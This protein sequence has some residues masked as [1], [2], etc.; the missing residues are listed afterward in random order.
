[1]KGGRKAVMMKAEQMVAN[2]DVLK[3]LRWAVRWA[4][5]KAVCSDERPNH[6]GLRTQS[7]GRLHRRLIARL[8][9]GHELS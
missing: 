1:M 9:D 6:R 8:E 5:W 7:G 2:T 3:E 4:M